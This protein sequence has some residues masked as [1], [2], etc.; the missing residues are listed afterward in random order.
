MMLHKFLGGVG[1]HVSKARSALLGLNR[2][3]LRP[4]LMRIRNNRAAQSRRASK[5]QACP[6]DVYE[7]SNLDERIAVGLRQGLPSARS[8]GRSVLSTNA[9]G[10]IVAPVRGSIRR[11]PIYKINHALLVLLHRGKT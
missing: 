4:M 3:L 1:R 7:V 6:A 2:W 8:G 11:I 9:K 5:G 10:G